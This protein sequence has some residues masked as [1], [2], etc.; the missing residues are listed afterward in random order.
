[1]SVRRASTVRFGFVLDVSSYSSRSAA[2]KIDVQQRVSV[3][4]DEILADLGVSR[5]DTYHHGTGDG[6]VVF[7]PG[8]IELHRAL[9]GLLRTAAQALAED[10]GRYRDRMRLRLAVLV[11][12]IGPAEIGFSGSTIVEAGRLVDS[13]EL[14]GALADHPE[15]DLVAFISDQLHT[16]V[17]GERHAGIDPDQFELIQIRNKEYHAPAWLWVAPRASPAGPTSPSFQLIAPSASICAIGIITGRILRVRG[18]DAWVSSENTDMEVARF[19]DFSIS[20]IV[21]YHGAR[22]DASGRVVD[23]VIAN[24]LQAVVSVRPVAPGTAFVTGSGALAD[25]NQVRWIIHVAAV[26]GEP[27]AGYRQVR[28]LGLCVRNALVEADRL[29]ADDPARSILI[30]MLGAGVAGGPVEPTATELVDA[31]ADYLAATPATRLRVINFL[32]YRSTEQRALERALRQH[33]AIAPSP[34]RSR[35]VEPPD[36]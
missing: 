14:R 26:T 5:A 31:A 2:Q 9:S 4:V 24:E 10:N 34:G 7:L 11:G 3:L 22:R 17:I 13:V 30:P 12:P 25:T 16:Y 36:H 23:D 29:G 6:M 8:E 35:S 21:R 32:A 33:P 27:G 20:S 18:V 28:D 15:A 19:N 1:M